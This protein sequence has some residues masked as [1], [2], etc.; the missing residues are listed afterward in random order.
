M[1]L[2]PILVLV[3]SI[4][5]AVVA[6]TVV[7]LAIVF[8]LDWLVRTRRINPF[9]PAARAIRRL[10]E[11]LVAPVER[12]ILRAGGTPASAPIWA[13]VGAVFIGIIAISSLDFLVQGYVALVLALTSGPLGL[14]VVLL[15]L[16]F[17]VLRLAV[18]IVVIV[19]WLPISP[20]SPWVR[21]AFT[22]S[23]PILRPLR[24]IVPRIAMFDITPIVAYFLLGILEWAILRI[25]GM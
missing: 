3:V 12:R 4:V 16:T 14:F 11:P 25:V 18:I 10:A 8:L 22:I 20:F 1:A 15:K 23:E 2:L 24:E 21:W 5:R 17:D 7:V 9:H 13:L 19:S 6:V